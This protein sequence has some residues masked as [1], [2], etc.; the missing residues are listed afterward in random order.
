MTAITWR[1]ARASPTSPWLAERLNE[2][3]LPTFT[4]IVAFVIASDESSPA[5]MPITV[6]GFAPAGASICKGARA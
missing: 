6:A 3:G 5:R 1:P 4:S 2:N